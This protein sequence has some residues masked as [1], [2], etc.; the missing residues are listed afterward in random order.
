[1][2][3]INHIFGG[4]LIL[5]DRSVS[6]VSGIEET[7]Q[8]LLRRLLTIAG[9]YIWQLDYGAGLPKLVGEIVDKEGLEAII[10][11]QII[12]DPGIDVTKP[13]KVKIVSSQVDGNFCEIKF[14]DKEN[15]NQIII[16]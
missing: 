4:D 1:M 8:R 14:F 12:N 10:R 7:K 5:S 15:N 9:E 2:S 13:L 3:S 11:Q 6:L 16:I